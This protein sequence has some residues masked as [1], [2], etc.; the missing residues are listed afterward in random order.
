MSEL[1]SD[2]IYQAERTGADAPALVDGKRCLDY[3]ELAGLVRVAAGGLVAIGLGRSERVAV[4]LDKRGQ[5]RVA[6][7]H[8]PSGIVWHDSRSSLHRDNVW[9]GYGGSTLGLV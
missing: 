7:R 4:Y 2:L 9:A 1:F 6:I 8:R 5:A 3:R